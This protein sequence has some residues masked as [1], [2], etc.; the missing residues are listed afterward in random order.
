MIVEVW[1][2][3]G[4]MGMVGMMMG[5][6]CKMGWMTME[7]MMRN[8]YEML[9]V[10]L[11]RM[12]KEWAGMDVPASERMMICEV[13]AKVLGDMTKL[14]MGARE[15]VDMIVEVWDRVGEIVR[16]EVREMT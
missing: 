10:M 5:Y 16:G 3:V 11:D 2:R 14:K 13:G 6:M 15:V 8:K 1:D 9:E 12:I 7:L 4:N